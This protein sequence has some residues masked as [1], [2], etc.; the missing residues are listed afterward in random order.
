MRT[1][2]DL[3]DDLYRKT[4]ALAALRGSSVKDLVIRALE[5]DVSPTTTKGIPGHRVKLPLMHLK[6][7]KKLDLT[8][9]NLDDLLG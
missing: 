3:P 6:H 2:I 7:S 8:G 4:K 1:T 5:R 9:F